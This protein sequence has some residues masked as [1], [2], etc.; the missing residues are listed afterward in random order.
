LDE[1]IKSEYNSIK[2]GFRVSMGGFR[3]AIGA[4]SIPGVPAPS[5]AMRS[6]GGSEFG[7][8]FFVTRQLQ[9]DNFEALRHSLNWEPGNMA[10]ALTLVAMSIQNVLTYLKFDY[11][12]QQ[13]EVRYIKPENE[14][15]FNK[16]WVSSMG[17]NRF[18]MTS[19]IDENSII[20]VSKKDILASYEDTQDDS[21]P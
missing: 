11:G 7:S 1:D 5:E 6:L 18:G 8:S 16:P 13:T 20:A 12:I 9:K 10:H 21:L 3:L 14:T 15:D 17:V 4:E 2:H 19:M